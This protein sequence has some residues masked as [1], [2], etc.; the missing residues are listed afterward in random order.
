[1]S[2]FGLHDPY[3]GIMKSRV[4]LR[5]PHIPVIDLTHAITPFVPEEAGYWL[6]CCYPQ[7]ASG[8]VH[9]AVVDPGV[10]SARAIVVLCAAGQYFVAPDNGLLGLIA[11]SCA[12]AVAHRVEADAL[13]ALQL[14]PRS[15][16]FHGRDVMGPLGA[17]LA[18]G[19]VRPEQLGARH[20]LAPG[21]LHPAVR[22]ADG[23]VR[24]SVAVIDHYGNALTTIPAAAIGSLRTVRLQPAGRALRLVGTYAE[25]GPGECVALIN[26]A[27]MLELAAGQASAAAALN[28]RP[29]QQVEVS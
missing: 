17:E 13:A 25:A 11:Q 2:D 8:T 14:A 28:V 7:F 6:Y 27:S 3:V 23:S 1:M 21:R 19:R 4:V 18:T 24:G 5:A 15:A 26:S 10:G 22:A 20:T 16:T 29:G 12:D 9:V